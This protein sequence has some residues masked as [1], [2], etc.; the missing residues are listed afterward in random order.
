MR[1]CS[2]M[3]CPSFRHR[4]SFLLKQ[5]HA[6]ALSEVVKVGAPEGLPP[7]ELGGHPAQKLHHPRAE[8]NEPTH[9][10]P[11]PCQEA[12]QRLSPLAPQELHVFPRKKEEVAHR[13]AHALGDLETYLRKEALE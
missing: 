3:G 7:V 2:L 5:L 13:R 12:E 8:G 9:D 1:F 4:I 6:G 10:L 11:Y